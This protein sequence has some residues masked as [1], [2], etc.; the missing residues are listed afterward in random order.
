MYSHQGTWAVVAIY[1]HGCV[2]LTIISGGFCFQIRV[3]WFII[4]WMFLY[5]CLPG[6]ICMWS[7]CEQSLGPTECYHFR[8]VCQARDGREH[9]TFTRPMHGMHH[10]SN[11]SGFVIFQFLFVETERRMLY[12]SAPDGFCLQSASQT[13]CP[14]LHT[15]RKRGWDDWGHRQ[16]RK[17]HIA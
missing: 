16:M 17:W 1:W 10:G 13:M 8:C 5:R 4:V 3:A 7:N 9:V 15:R 11:G 12:W 6:N 2:V 14:S